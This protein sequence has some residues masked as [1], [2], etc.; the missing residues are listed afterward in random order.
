MRVPRPPRKSKTWHHE[1]IKL[2]NKQIALKAQYRPFQTQPI[3]NS[4]V[5][6]V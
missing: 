3:L 6:P 4:L 1:Q 2:P 5:Q